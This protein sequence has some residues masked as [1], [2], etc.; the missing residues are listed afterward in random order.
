MQQCHVAR[1]Q[2]F[3]DGGLLGV[4]QAF[5]EGQEGERVGGKD[6]GTRSEQNLG[7]REGA[8]C[9]FTSELPRTNIT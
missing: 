1:S 8:V 2:S 3:A 6:G 5:V 9:V 4:V 7:G